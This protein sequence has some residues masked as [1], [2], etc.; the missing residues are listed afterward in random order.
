MTQENFHTCFLTLLICICYQSV[1]SL[2]LN[3]C[4]VYHFLSV[5]AHEEL[6]IFVKVRGL[7]STSSHHIWN[8]KF[9]SIFEV[10]SSPSNFKWHAGEDSYIII[11]ILLSI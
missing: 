4:H 7:G 1:K 6:W 3:R 9:L 11:E 2:S 8:N 10:E 5:D